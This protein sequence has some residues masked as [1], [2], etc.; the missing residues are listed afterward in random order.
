[1]KNISVTDGLD[2]HTLLKRSFVLKYIINRFFFILGSGK[3]W[4]KW[5]VMKTEN[6]IKVDLK[7]DKYIMDRGKN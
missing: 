6:N 4:C 2:W 5:N 1:M 7:I 3:F